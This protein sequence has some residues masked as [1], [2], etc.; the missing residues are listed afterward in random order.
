MVIVGLTGGIGSGKSTIAKALKMMGVGIYVCDDEAKRLM[1]TDAELKRQ[2]SDL[3][4]KDI[5]GAEGLNRAKMAEIVF[6]DP[7]VLAKVNALVH[8][9]VAND[10]RNWAKAQALGGAKW[11]VCESAILFES[12]FNNLADKILVVSLPKELRA[13]R[14]AERDHTTT[15]KIEQRMK[16]QMDDEELRARADYIISPDD[17]HLILPQLIELNNRLQQQ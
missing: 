13:Q 6:N 4:G 3:L 5:Y 11:V 15:E 7:S 1:N 17:K 8:P 10:F 2:L 9:C 12:G 14:A 16:S